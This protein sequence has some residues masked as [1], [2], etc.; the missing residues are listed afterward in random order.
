M[1]R[2]LPPAPSPEQPPPPR[3][4]FWGLVGAACLMSRQSVQEAGH[5][6]RQPQSVTE[7]QITKNAQVF[8]QFGW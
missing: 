4:S 8:E 6:P 2:D 5:S 7:T 3:N 1:T